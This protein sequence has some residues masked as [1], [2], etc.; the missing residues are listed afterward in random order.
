MRQKSQ[1][2]KSLA[3]VNSFHLEERGNVIERRCPQTDADGRG[4]Y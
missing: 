1:T 4:K 3:P 2:K